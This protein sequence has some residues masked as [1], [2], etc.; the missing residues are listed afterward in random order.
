MV[1]PKEV[2]E[3]EKISTTAEAYIKMPFIP[4]FIILC[5]IVFSVVFIILIPIIGCCLFHICDMIWSYGI[6]IVYKKTGRLIL[7]WYY[8]GRIYHIQKT[9]PELLDHRHFRLPKYLRNQ[10]DTEEFFDIYIKSTNKSNAG[11][12]KVLGTRRKDTSS[13]SELDIEVAYRDIVF[14]T[15]E[16]GELNLTE[17]DKKAKRKWRRKLFERAKG[18][19]QSLELPTEDYGSSSSDEETKHN[20]NIW[21]YHLKENNL[22]KSTSKFT[23]SELNSAKKTLLQELREER[24]AKLDEIKKRELE[25]QDAGVGTDSSISTVSIKRDPTPYY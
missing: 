1:P 13:S 9:Q 17:E 2:L 19:R 11:G 6:S 3:L 4:L 16:E 18:R 21:E 12:A 24:Q 22:Y 5:F 15:A 8:K 25:K 10:S 20:L 7:I 14:T 23:P